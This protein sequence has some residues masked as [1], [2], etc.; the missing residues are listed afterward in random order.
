MLNTTND[1]YT[2]NRCMEGDGLREYLKKIRKEKGLSQKT[3][4]NKLSVSQQYYSL[5]EKGERKDSLSAMM[6]CKLAKIFDVPVVELINEEDAFE[7][8]KSVQ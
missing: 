3:I 2:I 6:L 5:I 1:C 7:K 4:A 8:S